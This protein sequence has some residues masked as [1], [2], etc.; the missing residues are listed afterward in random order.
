MGSRLGMSN[1]EQLK[2]ELEGLW[3]QHLR[4]FQG[5]L[6]ITVEIWKV[7]EKYD[8]WYQA[9]LDLI[10]THYPGNIELLGHFDREVRDCLAQP[11]EPSHQHKFSKYVGYQLD[12]ARAS[13]RATPLTGRSLVGA[14][15]TRGESNLTVTRWQLRLTIITIFLSIVTIVISLLVR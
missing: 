2:S 3:R 13:A 1:L 15:I 7:T 11:F 12:L 5:N 4:Q 6:P 14:L 8:E 9:C 10:S